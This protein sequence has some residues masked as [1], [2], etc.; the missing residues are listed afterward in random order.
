MRPLRSV[1][2]RLKGLPGAGH[3]ALRQR[4]KRDELEAE[5]LEQDLLHEALPL[6]PAAADRE[7]AQA[8]LLAYAGAEA[9]ELAALL[10]ALD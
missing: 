5:R 2:R 9:P 8:N 6:A 4:I 10:S 1:R 7:A 3:E